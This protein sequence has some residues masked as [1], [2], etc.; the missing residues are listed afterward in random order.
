MAGRPHSQGRRVSPNPSQASPSGSKSTTSLNSSSNNR[1]RQRSSALG[2][3]HV[4][5]AGTDS[6]HYPRSSKAERTV[7]GGCGRDVGEGEGEGEC[8]DECGG[9]YGTDA[10]SLL[11]PSK[12]S[13]SS[14]PPIVSRGRSPRAVDRNRVSRS[15]SRSP[16]P[17]RQSASS[18]R[19]SPSPARVPMFPSHLVAS[20]LY[21]SGSASV[22]SPLSRS[23]SRSPSAACRS[24]REMLNPHTLE[25]SLGSRPATDGRTSHDGVAGSGAKTEMLKSSELAQRAREAT[26][27]VGLANLPLG[28]PDSRGSLTPT[29]ETHISSTSPA[30]ESAALLLKQTSSF[31]LVSD[32]RK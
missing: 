1:S 25:M 4:P 2:H 11:L 23:R 15:Y 8:E 32:A 17:V 20:A 7:D 5:P 19:R 31:W 28:S 26:V 13:Q 10:S 22:P 29:S 6:G 18:L 21:P 3:A 14:R 30:V 16:S 24:P 9:V 27:G 12:G